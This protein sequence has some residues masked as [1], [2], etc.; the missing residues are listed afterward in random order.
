MRSMRKRHTAVLWLSLLL[1]HAHAHSPVLSAGLG[2]KQHN[3]ASPGHP[4]VCPGYTFLPT[5]LLV[6]SL[7]KSSQA[8]TTY[9]AQTC[10]QAGCPHSLDLLIF[11]KWAWIAFLISKSSR[12]WNVSFVFLTVCHKCLFLLVLPLLEWPLDAI[13][14][15]SGPCS[16]LK[17][18]VKARLVLSWSFFL[19][20]LD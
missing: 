3:S 10:C 6:H 4:C 14:N 13:L 18:E 19:D 7:N 5:C 12:E 11:E 17:V 2:C 1:W 9:Q 20:L 16:R 15:E 8:W